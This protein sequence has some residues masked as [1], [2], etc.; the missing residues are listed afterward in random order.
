MDARNDSQERPEREL[1]RP[2]SRGT[3]CGNRGALCQAQLAQPGTMAGDPL[4]FLRQFTNIRQRQ[5]D[6]SCKKQVGLGLNFAGS[7]ASHP[8]LVFRSRCSGLCFVL[9]QG[10]QDPNSS[11]SKPQPRSNVKGTQAAYRDPGTTQSHTPGAGTELS[12]KG[13]EGQGAEDSTVTSGKWCT[14]T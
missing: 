10:L 12:H 1:S 13:K 14:P 2:L 9:P 11:R 5:E 4:A 8:A 3:C 6:A 7:L